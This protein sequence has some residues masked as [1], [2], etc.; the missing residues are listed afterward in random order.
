[1]GGI[2]LVVSFIFHVGGWNNINISRSLT[3]YKSESHY[4]T[5][6]TFRQCTSPGLL[7]PLCYLSLCVWGCVCPTWTETEVLMRHF[8]S[9]L[10]RTGPVISLCLEQHSDT[11]IGT[12]GRS[13]S[14]PQTPRRH[15][16][17]VPIS[18]SSCSQGMMSPLY[19]VPINLTASSC[20][21]AWGSLTSL[22]TVDG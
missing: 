1:M 22:E 15:I 12:S 19:R 5:S 20:S 2:G 14:P 9:N 3:L 11:G 4:R 6:Q 17:A 21:H 7:L 10:P 13:H 8:G 16:E 18:V